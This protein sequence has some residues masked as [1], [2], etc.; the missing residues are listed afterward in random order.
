MHLHR[1]RRQEDEALGARLEG[2]HQREQRVRAAFPRAAGGAPAGVVRLVEDDQVPRL[3]VEQHG[4]AVLPAHQVA[5]RDDHGLFVPAARVDLALV[6]PAQRARRVAAQ[7][8]P[9]V[10]RPV[11]VEL[12]AQLD[13]PLLQDRPR[14]EDENALRQAREP[15]L[16]QQQPRLDGLAEADL[17]RD[18]E[19]RRPPRVETIEGPEL[20]R[21]G[22]DG[23]RGLAHSRP[24]AGQRR[25]LPDEC[26]DEPPA[27]GRRERG[28]M[29]PDL[30]RRRGRPALSGRRGRA[31]RAA[32][33]S[34]SGARADP[35][36]GSAAG[37]AGRRRARRARWR[38]GSG[39]PRGARSSVLRRRPAPA[40]DPSCGRR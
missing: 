11:E 4:G 35:A 23:R 27:V 6:A 39:W 14:R 21:P 1:R 34:P 18:Q 31:G 15:R 10:D 29:R 36:A 12:L 37:P 33:A 25:R 32:A 30:S 38:A 3:G 2:A 17:V 26:P 19:L 13:L 9:V 7:P 8:A 20:V 28:R 22:L 5:R 24:A 40:R 16:A